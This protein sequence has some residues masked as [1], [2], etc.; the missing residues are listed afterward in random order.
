MLPDEFLNIFCFLFFYAF[1][2]HSRAPPPNLHT[3]L[4]L[5]LLMSENIYLQ[6]G[7]KLA[8]SQVLTPPARAVVPL[9]KET[10]VPFR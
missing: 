4:S 7:V 1:L 3:S 6:R 9:L 10:E 8:G 2:A 5:L